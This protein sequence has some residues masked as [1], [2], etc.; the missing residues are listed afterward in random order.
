M[1]SAKNLERL[2][3]ERNK[4]IIDHALTSNTILYLKHRNISRDSITNENH[5]NFPLFLIERNKIEIK[6]VIK[7]IGISRK[8]AGIQTF[9]NR[10]CINVFHTLRNFFS[11]VPVQLQRRIF[12]L[13]RC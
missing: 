7:E 13:V 3:H 2:A 11:L 6:E 5:V 1:K 4:Y 10:H 8:T 9:I 12:N